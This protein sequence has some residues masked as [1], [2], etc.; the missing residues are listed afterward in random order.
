MRIPLRKIDLSFVNVIKDMLISGVQS[1]IDITFSTLTRVFNFEILVDDSS[2]EI[3]SVNNH[4]QIKT[5]GVQ[6]SHLNPNC[7]GSG[8]TQD[9]NGALQ[10]DI[11]NTTIEINSSNKLAVKDSILSALPLDVTRFNNNLSSSDDTVQKALDT[12]DDLILESSTLADIDE[13][14]GG[15]GIT[16]FQSSIDGGASSTNPV[17]NIDGGNSNNIFIEQNIECGSASSIYNYQ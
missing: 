8:L 3:D 5:D 4:L 10:P 16:I 11:D 12:L 2:I 1:G 7:A 9:V 14:D 13:I 15:S 6:N 17:Y